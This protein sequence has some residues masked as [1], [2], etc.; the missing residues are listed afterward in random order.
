MMQTLSKTISVTYVKPGKIGGAIAFGTPLDESEE[1]RCKVGS[2]LLMRLPAAGE[3]WQ[4][5]GLM[6]T[7][8]KKDGTV[9]PQLIVH[10][11]RPVN[12]P[13][14]SYLSTLLA[15][16]PAFRGF[17]FGATKVGKLID[18]FDKEEDLIEVLDAGHI[19]RLTDSSDGKYK[20]EYT[21]ARRLVNAWQQLR[22]QN[23]AINFLIDHKF[24]ASLARKFMHLCREGTVERLKSNPYSLV[25]FGGLTRNIWRTMENCRK[26]LDLSI[27]FD[28]RLVGAIEHVLYEHLR[29]GHT[30]MTKSG[31]LAVS[32]T[33]LTLPTICSV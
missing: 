9:V 7:Y 25:C 10:S 4:F 29:D 5:E 31:L 20:L 2:K 3:F 26:N 32:Y 1:I 21:M 33:H 13:N 18:K 16:H 27:D 8:T 24:T 11:C 17:A 19:F 22:N 12:L 15:K 23:E 14:A 30:V 6:S 28:G